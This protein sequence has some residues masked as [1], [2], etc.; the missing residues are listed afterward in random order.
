MG[1]AAG[2][3]GGDPHSPLA[4]P[5]RILGRARKWY[6][7]IRIRIICP[8]GTPSSRSHPGEFSEQQARKP[9]S[10]A[11]RPK[12]A[13]RGNGWETSIP[14][15][16]LWGKIG[17]SKADMGF[18]VATLPLPVSRVPRR[19]AQEGSWGASALPEAGSVLSGGS[20]GEPGS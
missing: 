1:K 3:P 20:P 13:E 9:L 15:T 16:V 4:Q 11:L 6:H 2:G 14:E 7:F 12:N 5:P 8:R 10:S 17:S 18:T 19:R